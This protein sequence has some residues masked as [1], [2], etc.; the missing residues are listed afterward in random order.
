MIIY[1]L[2]LLSLQLWGEGIDKT[3]LAQFSWLIV[4]VYELALPYL[5]T[6]KNSNIWK[7]SI[8][9]ETAT[10]IIHH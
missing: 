5:E 6:M 2:Y 10:E 3:F 8:F 7:D 4:L 1:L 9:R